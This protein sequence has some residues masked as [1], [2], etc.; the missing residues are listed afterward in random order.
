MSRV[1]ATTLVLQFEIP[2]PDIELYNAIEH[3]MNELV[4]FVMRRLREDADDPESF[5]GVQFRWYGVAEKTGQYGIDIIG[6]HETYSVRNIID[7]I[8]KDVRAAGYELDV[9]VA[10][11]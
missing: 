3:L 7:H 8:R 11:S 10:R 5:N 4:R 9:Q 1:M 2:A 6:P